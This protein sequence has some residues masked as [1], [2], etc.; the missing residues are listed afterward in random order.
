MARTRR[1]PQTQGN[2]L[3]RRPTIRAVAEHSMLFDTRQASTYR[4]QQSITATSRQSWLLLG[5]VAMRPSIVGHPVSVLGKLE[6]TARRLSFVPIG[7]S[8]CLQPVRRY[9]CKF[10]QRRTQCFADT[11][12]RLSLRT[13]ANTY[14]ESVRCRPRDLIRYAFPQVPL[15]L[16]GCKS[17]RLACLLSIR[18]PKND[19]PP[20]ND[21]KSGPDLA[22]SF[23]R[24][25]A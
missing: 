14:V 25:R 12:S 5:S 9:N 16:V 21:Q 10:V 7:R 15:G 22:Q 6:F 19:R 24:Y 13:S 3:R 2:R 4:L 17:A 20:E 8:R 11:L 18:P 1:G 23:L